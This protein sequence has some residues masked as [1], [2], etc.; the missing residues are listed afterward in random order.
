VEVVGDDSETVAA[1][2]E[3]SISDDFLFGVDLTLPEPLEVPQ[4]TESPSNRDRRS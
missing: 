1:A 4:I 3:F 2:T